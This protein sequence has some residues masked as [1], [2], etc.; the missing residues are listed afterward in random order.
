MEPWNLGVPRNKV[1]VLLINRKDA[2]AG[3]IALEDLCRPIIFNHHRIHQNLRVANCLYVQFPLPTS[4]GD[5][6]SEME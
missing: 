3:P 5:D 2:D 4:S 1:Y 6:I